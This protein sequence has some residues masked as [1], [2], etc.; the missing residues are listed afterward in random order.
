[1]N[2]CAWSVIAILVFTVSSFAQYPYS[3]AF[4]VRAG[5]RR[6]HVTSIVQDGR[7]LLWV[8]SEDGLL[9]GDG[10]RTD[11]VWSANGARIT[12]LMAD[13]NGL[14]AATARGDVIRCVGFRC[15]TL[16]HDTVIAIDPVRCLLRMPNGA[17]WV[18]TYGA[19]VLFTSE[20]R[21]HLT[22]RVEGLPDEHVNAMCVID[23]FHVAVAT[24]QGIAVCD[25]QGH[26]LR[27]I[28]EQ[29]GAPDNLVLSLAHAEGRRIWAGTDLSGVFSCDPLSADPRI[30]I[31]DTAWSHGPVG[32]LAA[33]D[34]TV[35]CGTTEHG[36]VV[37]DV[38][39]DLATY[40]PRGIVE[41]E[42]THV[43]ALMRAHD[44]AV[45][46]CDGTERVHRADPNILYVPDHEGVDLHN[47]T[48]LSTDV[49]GNIWFAT[50][51]GI[52]HH[53]GGFADAFKLTEVGI[54]VD[55]AHTVVALHGAPDGSV[56]A[57]TLGQGVYRIDRDGSIRQFTEKEGLCSNNV[58][59]IRSRAG[60]SDATI[61]F[62]TLGGVCEFVPS[63]VPGE[64]TFTHIDV[65]GGGFLFDILPM[66]DGS[67]LAATDGSGVVRVYANGATSVMKPAGQNTAS[68]YSLCI[69]KHG[70]A[71]ACGPATGLCSVRA[72]GLHPFATGTAPFDQ[73]VFSISPYADHILVLGKSGLAA[74][75]PA[76]S[77][78]L[79]LGSA[80]GLEDVDASL[81]TAC[82][83]R[84]GALWL[85][86]D[87]GL[88]RLS[89]SLEA[90]SARV[91][92][93]IT[94]LSWADEQLPLDSL[95]RLDYEQNFLTFHFAG[96]HY[97]AP[98][99]IR[100]EY[101]LIGFDPRIR[102]TRDRE[103][104]WPRLPF[105]H[106]RFEVRAAIG[107]EPAAGEWSSFAFSIAAPWWRTPWAIVIGTFLITLI[108]WI[109]IRSRDQRLRYRDRMEK[110]KARFQ[111]DALRSQVNPHFLFNSFN[112]L[113]ELIEEDSDKAVQHAEHLSDFFREMLQVRDKDLIP[114]MEEL[115]LV[116][117]YFY[118]EQHRFGKRIALHNFVDLAAST[119]LVPPLALQLL[120]ENV[121]KHN[122]A[123]LEDPLTVTIASD[124]RW[125]SVSNPFR[126][127]T[128]PPRSTGFGI[129]SIKQRYATFTDRP[130][131]V[132]NDGTTFTVR[133]PL[134]ETAP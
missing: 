125:L 132:I 27:V 57:A 83:D 67:V 40:L 29:H 72:D 1:M 94:G 113:I 130:V 115:Q 107:K 56:W 41:G 15:D 90:L 89:P 69:D 112:T 86:C 51:Q 52:F 65:P 106:F 66:P 103:V 46:W 55:K 109:L 9:S 64:G 79:D 13:T 7:G 95:L 118:L 26:V 19:G 5:Q 53:G 80:T 61:W 91:P 58:L 99:D 35:W 129:E 32:A 98:E 37:C 54:H 48:A 78:I 59:A 128:E 117:T 10:E 74:F 33:S 101:R 124:Q 39:H 50:D 44:G 127:R 42:G 131:E 105:G 68:F 3:R 102:I 31:I 111:L 24:D 123:T 18:G 77:S 11:L 88:V 100:F 93:V 121:L 63:A 97:A 108:I 120:V 30:A 22:H 85:A 62:A 23:S 110:E 82:L 126:P 70:N 49:N 38:H 2:R 34:G 45:W 116:D 71:W 104:T 43:L 92:T 20:D 96:L 133:L 119:A 87:R 14:I 12:A 36:N 16:L 75:D 25:A 8:A 84:N 28:N 73:N 134:I 76:D 60:A 21:L 6:P 47:I 4:D 114:L 17:L 122:T 81:N